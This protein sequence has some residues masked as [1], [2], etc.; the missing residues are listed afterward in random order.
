MERRSKLRMVEQRK[1]ARAAVE[2]RHP[3]K[4]DGE[5]DVP[6]PSDKAKPRTRAEVAR[7]ARFPRAN[8]A[9][10]PRSR[11]ALEIQCDAFKDLPSWDSYSPTI[12]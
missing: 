9:P 6:S 12:L 3:V 4:R 11:R 8:Y 2:A 10:R 7:E 5:A 1:E